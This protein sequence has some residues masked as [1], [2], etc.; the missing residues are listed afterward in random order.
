M[1]MLDADAAREAV[2][3]AAVLRDLKLCGM[4]DAARRHPAA[5]RER[6]DGRAFLSALKQR[7]VHAAAAPACTAAVLL[8]C[9]AEQ[10]IHCPALCSP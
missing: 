5:R 1:G 10:P 9:H 2:A 3:L 7:N 4:D 6:R 8:R